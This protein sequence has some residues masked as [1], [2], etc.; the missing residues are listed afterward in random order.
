MAHQMILMQKGN[1][2]RYFMSPQLY[3]LFSVAALFRIFE[4][5]DQPEGISYIEHFYD[6]FITILL[7]SF[8]KRANGFSSSRP[9]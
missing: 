2:C 7:I 5:S 8:L 1:L 4:F 9:R 6:F 3:F